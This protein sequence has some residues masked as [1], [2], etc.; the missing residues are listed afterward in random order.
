M[1][2]HTH[3]DTLAKS[4]LASAEATP[5]AAA[6]R[7]GKT[8]YSFAQLL[9]QSLRLASLLGSRG[10]RHNEAV[11]V[12]MPRCLEAGVAMYGSMLGNYVFVP[13]DPSSP[14]NI[15]R[16]LFSDYGIK[17]LVT[18]PQMRRLIDQLL[19]Q[20]HPL[21]TI[22]GLELPNDI[23]SNLVS[24]SWSELAELPEAPIINRAKSDDAAYVIHTSGSTGRPKGIV[25]THKS[26]SSY[27]RLCAST[28]QLT[29]SDTI[30]SH[31]P[32]H[33]DMCTFGFLAGV[34]AGATTQIIPDAHVRVPASLSTLIEQSEVTVW[35]SVPQVL[36]QLLSNGMLEQ[37]ELSKMRLVVYAGEA[38]AP[39]RLLE[40]H[41]YFT[42]ASVCN[43]YGPAE[44]NQCT[45]YFA[46]DTDELVSL[47]EHNQSLPIGNPWPETK[48]LIVDENDEKVSTGSSGEL[49]IHSSTM[50]KEYWRH[51]QDVSKVFYA[52]PEDNLRYYRTGD[53][54]YEDKQGRYML[55][56]R[57]GRQ[58]KVRGMRVELDAIELLLSQH[59]EVIDAAVVS[60]AASDDPG[61]CVIFAA[62][63]SRSDVAV[64]DLQRYLSEHL[65]VHAVPTVVNVLASMPLTSGGKVDRLRVLSQLKSIT[66]D[67]VTP[68]YH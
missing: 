52:N 17:V 14:V 56:G 45:H 50:M 1:A 23:K 48:A 53:V 13:I 51:D 3:I 39:S 54:A 47:A 59:A 28:F 32:L 27:A 42:N 41:R 46:N 57:I 25:H 30:G 7:Y 16:Q 18:H 20:E 2:E 44:T 33:T 12:L 65:P 55:A 5:D 60:H 15:I 10:V 19:M 38:L 37:R 35:Y 22:V 29:S 34:H 40:L 43:V 64:S 31:G 6:F 4:L 11:A 66:S 26:G 9:S 58:V 8:E 68:V 21:E 49:L 62:V 24:V 36:V 61:S 63:T 67:E